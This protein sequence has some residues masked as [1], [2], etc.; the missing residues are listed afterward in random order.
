MDEAVY[1]ERM[2]ALHVQPTLLPR[3]LNLS[4]SHSL[5]SRQIELGSYIPRLYTFGR[6]RELGPQTFFVHSFSCFAF[7]TVGWWLFSSHLQERERSHSNT[8]VGKIYSRKE[9][10]FIAL[11][12]NT[13]HQC[14][15]A[16]HL[17]FYLSWRR[18]IAL[19]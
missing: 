17:S 18:K 9:V 8:E 13:G 14:T 19:S 6:A 10:H 7:T 3:C 12:R 11:A 5:T 1:L 4:L 15:T 2:K 16:V